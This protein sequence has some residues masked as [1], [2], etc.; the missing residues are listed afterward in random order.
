MG[1]AQE[2]KSLLGLSLFSGFCWLLIL[3]SFVYAA[4]RKLAA[5]CRELE[6]V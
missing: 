2:D 1:D 4:L 6:M 5:S 3:V